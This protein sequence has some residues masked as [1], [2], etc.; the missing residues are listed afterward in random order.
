MA[1]HDGALWA[2][3]QLPPSPAAA[4]GAG[5]AGRGYWLHR[6][7]PGSKRWSLVATQ[8]RASPPNHEQPQMH[9]CAHVDSRAASDLSTQQMARC[10]PTSIDAPPAPADHCIP[11]ARAQGAGPWPRCESAAAL[12][13]GGRLVV[14]GGA[15]LG[16]PRRLLADAHCLDLSSSPPSWQQLRLRVT[17]GAAAAAEAGAGLVAVAGHAGAAF[18]EAAV[19][20]GGCRRTDRREPEALVQVGVFAE[21]AAAQRQGGLGRGVLAA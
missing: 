17:G 19:F 13:P 5:S 4:P 7:N 21:R 10:H 20:V 14:F 8:V 12:L 9:M 1:F 2:L 3:P 15:A 6:L 18:G 16:S 11:S